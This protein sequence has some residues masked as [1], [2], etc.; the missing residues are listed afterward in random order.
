MRHLNKPKWHVVVYDDRN[1]HSPRPFNDIRAATAEEAIREMAGGY[2]GEQL[3]TL[4]FTCGANAIQSAAGLRG[5]RTVTIEDIIAAD[6]EE[7]RARREAG[8]WPY[9][10]MT[11]FW[12]ARRMKP[13]WRGRRCRVLASGRLN[14]ILIEFENGSRVVTGAGNVR[15]L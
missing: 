13:E 1:I 15:P 8:E 3:D 10:T 6:Q 4:T 12:Y 7:H 5:H 2:S 14:N 9:A 11:H